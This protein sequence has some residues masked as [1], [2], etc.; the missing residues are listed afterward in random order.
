[1]HLSEGTLVGP[2]EIRA[3]L[4][5]GGMGEVYRARDTRLQRD[6]AVKVLPMTSQSDAASRSRFESEA[7]ALAALNHP[8]IATIYDVIELDDHRAIVM[9][10]VAGTT[11]AERLQTG[12]LSIRASLDLGIQISDALSVAHAA[13]IVHR[14]LKPA[15]VIVT[16]NGTAKVLDFGIAKRNEKNDAATDAATAAPALTQTGA[17]VG[18]L[19][20]MS[21]EQAHGQPADTR[22]DIFSLGVLLYECLAGQ[23]PFRGDTSA[24]MIA[25]VV[26]DDPTPLRTAAPTTPRALERCVMRCLEK[27]PDHRY[28][29]AIDLKATLED[30]RE[31]LRAPESTAVADD[32]ERH[33]KAAAR[34]TRWR[35]FA[36]AATGFGLGIIAVVA[37]M[38]PPPPTVVT[39]RV[40]P[41]I[42]EA[43]TPSSPAWSP[44][45]R[46]LA[47]V[48]TVSGQ[49]QI[50]VRALDS[51]QSTQLTREPTTGRP[52][53]WSP[54]GSKVY[55][56]RARDGNLM[57]IG[58][59]GGEAQMVTQNLDGDKGSPGPPVGTSCISPDGRT[60]VFA[61]GLSP[62]QLWA[63][64]VASRNA[65]AMTPTGLPTSLAN[66]QGLAFSPD[67]ATLALLGNR[68]AL[69]QS[70][71]MWLVNWHDRS[72]RQ[73]LAD[74]PYLAADFSLGWMPDSRRIVMSGSPLHGE[75][76][77]LLVVDTVGTTVRELTPGMDAQTSPTVT[78]DGNRIAFVSDRNERDLLQLP[79]DGGQPIALLATSRMESSPDMSETGL[80]AY[81]SDA[82]G[83]P[84]VHLRSATD[85]W[86]RVLTGNSQVERDR[87]MP[88]VEV[89]I[90]RD[91][92]RVAIGTIG[93]EHLIWLYPVAG[94]S[95]VRL[96]E[97]S[98][99]QHGPSWSP[100]GNWIAY[101][102]LV[103]G[104]WSIVKAPIGGGAVVTLDGAAAGG[105]ATDWSPTGEWIAHMRRDG[106]H[107]VSPN[108]ERPRVLAGLR[109][110]L[111]RFSHDGS[112]L[113]VVRRGETRSWELIIWD[114]AASRELRTVTL[115]L[116]ARTEVQAL[117]L[118]PD[119]SALILSAGATTSD[120]W[121]LERFDAPPSPWWRRWLD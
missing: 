32:G 88:P 10:L 57:S 105:G 121:L 79:I 18:T 90:S 20:Y 103:G 117:A 56:V 3:P 120:I 62:V 66:V 13:G 31:D 69:N 22:S 86:S 85:K 15:N 71:G 12:A 17:L 110:Q 5:S 30:I 7:K 115:P 36:Y 98:T 113:L 1:M 109:A 111:F 50:L 96:D 14:D 26:R 95:P 114:V 21:P 74:A 43:T 52:P 25:A 63:L 6:V 72:A 106:I 75:H 77:R 11:L 118:T 104:T 47:Y 28:Q 73:V 8:H 92:Q 101:H 102:R 68:S 65:S 82:N 64:D 100:D 55:F 84:A 107:L 91:A 112:R 35:Q 53:F 46:M 108:G 9:E 29:A 116:S 89:R 80:L 58:A 78:R 16:P 27:R 97:E 37:T 99:D 39:P 45:G 38:A 40:R 119:D 48:D 93:D 67:G 51:T 41:F 33:I 24:A 2:Y 23:R 54:D 49:L 83:A 87:G 70:R 61:R 42:V 76:A 19:G 94:G 60:I 81:V 34:S 4:G 59:G 44:D